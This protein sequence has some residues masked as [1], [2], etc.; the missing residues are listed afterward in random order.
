MPDWDQHYTSIDIGDARVADV[1][2]MNEHLLTGHGRALDYACGTAA[3]GRWLEERGYEVRAWDNSRVVVD[4]LSVFSQ[5]N[6]LRLTAELHDLEQMHPEQPNDF[7][8]VVCSFFLYRPTIDMIPLLLKSG[9][10]LFYQTFCGSQLQ[11]RGP[12]SP[13]FRLKTGELLDMFSD[14]QILYYREDGA[15]GQGVNSMSDQAL[16][17]A[18]KI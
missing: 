15:F 18:A 10:L 9:G 3:N 13:A 17:V 5:Q 16:L 8:L 14:M 1:L 12:T 6:D 7:D 4:K 2:S 11:G